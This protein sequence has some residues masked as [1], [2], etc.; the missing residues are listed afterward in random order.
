MK[1]SL[2]NILNESKEPE[3]EYQIRYI[4]TPVFYKRKKGDK[5]WGFTTDKEFA[6][7]A[8]KS[9]IIKWDEKHN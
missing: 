8:H 6:E 9:K 3:F 4:D 1:L 5:T 2:I 7:N